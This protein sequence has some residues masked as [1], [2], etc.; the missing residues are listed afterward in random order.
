MNKFYSNNQRTLLF[1]SNL[2]MTR[3]VNKDGLYS[4]PPK[5]SLLQYFKL[6]IT[7]GYGT[8]NRI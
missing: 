1:K 7:N 4:I 8:S 2:N 3:D 5:L 6:G